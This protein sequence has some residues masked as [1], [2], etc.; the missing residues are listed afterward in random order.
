LSSERLV[1]GSSHCGI[2]GACTSAFAG[3]QHYR[4]VRPSGAN[5]QFNRSGSRFGEGFCFPATV[6]GCPT[7]IQQPLD[8]RSEL[9]ASR[10]ALDVLTAWMDVSHDPSPRTFRPVLIFQGP[11]GSQDLVEPAGFP[12]T[13]T[14]RNPNLGSRTSGLAKT[15]RDE[16]IRGGEESRHERPRSTRK[17]S[18]AL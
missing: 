1:A 7:L 4:T 8:N 18:E 14:Q 2:D 9:L 16:S 6:P 12:S 17:T 15:R 10:V 11:V 13:S 5:Q 3:R